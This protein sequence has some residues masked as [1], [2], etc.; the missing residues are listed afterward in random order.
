MGRF[1]RR[2]IDKRARILTIRRTMSGA[3]IVEMGKTERSR[4]QVPLTHRALEAL[5]AIPPRLDTPLLFPAPR[6]AERIGRGRVDQGPVV[7][8]NHPDARAMRRASVKIDTP[9]A[10]ASDANVLLRS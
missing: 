6:A 2:D 5:D 1:E 8:L 4:R 9:A 10:R 3:E 7:L